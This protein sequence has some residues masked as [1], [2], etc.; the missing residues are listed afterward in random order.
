MLQ[1]DEKLSQLATRVPSQLHRAVKLHCIKHGVSVMEFVAE[2]LQEKL[3]AAEN[4]PGEA[5]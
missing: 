4:R 5:S 1:D 3:D 2:A